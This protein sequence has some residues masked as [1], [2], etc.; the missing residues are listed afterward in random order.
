MKRLLLSIAAIAISGQL[1]STPAEA[2]TNSEFRQQL[3]DRIGNAQNQAAANRSRSVLNRAVLGTPSRLVAFVRITNSTLRR[4]VVDA[5]RGRVANTI[6]DTA[7]F[8]YFRRNGGLDGRFN[9]VLRVVLRSLPRSQK[10]ESLANQVTRTIERRFFRFN[11]ATPEDQNIISS[12]VFTNLGLV[13]PPP[14]S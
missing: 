5:Q 11:P 10:R 4:V 12:G 6:I 1:L 2:Q 14:V 9:G 8:A 3:L 7:L 13:V